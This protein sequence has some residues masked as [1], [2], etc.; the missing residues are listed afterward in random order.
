MRRSLIALLG[1][2]LAGC[3][4]DAA[5]VEWARLEGP[6]FLAMQSYPTVSGS[7]DRVGLDALVVD[8]SGNP[9]VA[10]ITWRACSPWVPIDVIERDCGLDRSL[11]L[12][13]ESYWTDDV[14]AAFPPDRGL[15]LFF[16]VPIIAELAVEGLRLVALKEVRTTRDLW[17][18]GRRN[19]R[20]EALLLDGRSNDGPLEPGRTYRLQVVLD[21]GSIDVVDGVLEQVDVHLYATAGDVS[22]SPIRFRDGLGV[23]ARVD[24]ATYTAPLDRTGFVVF[25]L[26]A[27]DGD[28]GTG[29]RSFSVQLRAPL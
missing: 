24:G 29:W 11:P 6:R 25:W 3:T 20:I 14:L 19:P 5:G 26:V 21:Y 10:P 27:V 2:G 9:V 17:E 13:S 16:D 8:A 12:T 23:H 7:N 28:G 15:P 4:S 22:R 1:L 18:P